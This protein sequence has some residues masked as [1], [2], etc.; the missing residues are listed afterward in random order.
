MER[1]I[2]ITASSLGASAIILGAFGAHSLKDKLSPEMLA[3]F[4][5]GVRYQMYHALMLLFIANSTSLTKKGRRIIYRLAFYGTILF[6]G[7]IYLLSTQSLSGIDIHAIG[8]VTPVGGLLLIVAW[9]WLFIDF[10][11]RRS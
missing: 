8:L 7:S 3:S 6:S 5:T 10:S 9:F 4:E 1:K 2:T 11:R